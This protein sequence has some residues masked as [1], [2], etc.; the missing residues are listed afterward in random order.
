MATKRIINVF[1]L[2]P[3]DGGKGG[4]VHKYSTEYDAHIILKVGGAQGSH[5]VTTDDRSFAF[6]QWGCGTFENI[7]THIT[8]RFVMSPDALVAEA[9][10]LQEAGVSDPW[11]LLTIDG[12]AICSTPYHGFAS[13]AREL[14]RGN[15]PRGTIGSGVGQAYRRFSSHPLL[16]FRAHELSYGD[17][18]KIAAKM[19][20]VRDN[21]LELLRNFFVDTVLKNDREEFDKEMA[22]FFDDYF[23]DYVIEEYDALSNILP[24]VNEYTHLNGLLHTP[25]TAIIENS[26]GVLTD[27]VVGFNPHTSALRTLPQFNKQ[28]LDYHKFNGEFINIGVHRAYSIRHGAGPLPTHDPSMNERLLPGSNKDENRYQGKVRVGPLDFVLLRYALAQSCKVDALAITWFDQVGLNG[29]WDVCDFYRNCDCNVFESH[30][31]IKPIP[32]GLADTTSNLRMTKALFNVM[33]TIETIQLPQSL[34]EQSELCCKIVQDKLQI[35]VD[36]IS[37]G[38]RDRNKVLR[39]ITNV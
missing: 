2:G 25:G 7:P 16:T 22:M 23:L 30:N 29:S 1:D 37:F 31:I 17:K 38:P 18:D 24:V 21:E 27:N 3:G 14:L 20:A 4:V 26:H 12:G 8:S 10:A 6:S 28:Y 9:Q 5:G 32:F 13:R 15:D 39:G 36:L 34:T 35:P 11:D 19:K 33:P